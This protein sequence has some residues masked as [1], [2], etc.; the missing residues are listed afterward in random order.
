MEWG[1]RVRR[2]VSRALGGGA[3]ALAFTR[4]CHAQYCMVY[5]IQNGGQGESRIL[6][7]S[8]AIVL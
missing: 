1:E 4:Y 8:H 6:R 5:G 7:N 2:S 3:V